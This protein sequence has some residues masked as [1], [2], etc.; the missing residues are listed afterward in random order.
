M[1]ISLSTLLLFISS[2][3]FAQTASQTPVFVENIAFNADEVIGYDKFD[4]LYFIKDNVLHKLKNGT[5][6]EYKNIS[7]GK[8]TKVDLLNPLKIIVFY[9]RFNTAVTLDNQ[10]NET[11]KINFSQLK[12]P[13]LVSKIGI[14]SQN[15][16]WVLDQNTQQ[17]YLYD[18]SNGTLKAVGTPISEEITFY[19]SNFNWF[20][21]RDNKNNWY[22]CSIFGTV[23]R[24]DL[25]TDFDAVLFSDTEF[26]FY[27]KNGKHVI[28]N[29]NTKK[30]NTLENLDNSFTSLTFKNQILSIFTNQGITNYKI[31]IP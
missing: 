21:W 22:Q 19:N 14:A 12:V 27:T 25:P 9:E 23:Q 2:F 6:L 20:E 18:T 30:I 11:L 24:L 5:S 17:L 28:F 16:L 4:F 1:K 13:L 31:T 10:L 29:R 7:L 15:Q 26:I 8:I 3:I